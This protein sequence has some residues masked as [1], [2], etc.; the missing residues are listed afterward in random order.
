MTDLHPDL[1]VSVRNEVLG[2]VLAGLRIG[3]RTAAEMHE[4]DL[5][6]DGFTYG[7]MAWRVSTHWIISEIGLVP[8]ASAREISN[9]L[10]VFAD[11]F[12]I[13]V[14]A[15]GAD[16]SWDPYTFDFDRGTQSKRSIPRRNSFSLQ[17]AFEDLDD[18]ALQAPGVLDELTIVHCGNPQDELVAVYVG[19]SIFD[20]ESG[21][22]RWAWL[23]QVFRFDGVVAA[24]ASDV[25]PFTPHDELDLPDVPVVLHDDQVD[26]TADPS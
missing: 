20:E 7:T 12:V 24:M 3:H 18:P 23:R 1:P 17:L 16:L 5:G 26:G 9:S 19:A 10:R 8:D 25:Q 2:A 15:G 13:S 14:Y 11:D 21:R 6:M 4:P 22:S